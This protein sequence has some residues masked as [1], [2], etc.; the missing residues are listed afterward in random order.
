MNEANYE[1]M[2][3]FIFRAENRTDVYINI[4]IKYPVKYNFM[5]VISEKIKWK[6]NWEK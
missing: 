6:G 1:K 4:F 2:L 3:F 5:L